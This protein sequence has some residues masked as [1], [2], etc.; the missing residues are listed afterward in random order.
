[1]GLTFTADE[2]AM[3]LQTM[4]NN[5]ATGNS[6]IVPEILKAN[7]AIPTLLASLFN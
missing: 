6:W 4:K 3:A 2:I 7:E 1:M 5:K